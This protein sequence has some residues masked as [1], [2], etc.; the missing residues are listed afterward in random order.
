LGIGI[1]REL[2]PWRKFMR[3]SAEVWMH[4]L[5]Y[6]LGHILPSLENLFRLSQQF[7]YKRLVPPIV[8][9]RKTLLASEQAQK[10]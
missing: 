5:P 7:W 3:L 6:E 9:W 2:S 10:R 4:H 1:T 8:F